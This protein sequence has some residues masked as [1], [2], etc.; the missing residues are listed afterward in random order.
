MAT[1]IDDMVPV[2]DNTGNL[3]VRQSTLVDNV[4]LMT[5]AN[6]TMT[7][8]PIMSTTMVNPESVSLLRDSNSYTVNNLNQAYPEPN[9]LFLK[10]NPDFG[11]QP[12]P[13]GYKYWIGNIRVEKEKDSSGKLVE[14]ESKLGYKP[15]W[16]T[17]YPNAQ[18]SCQLWADLYRC[19]ADGTYEKIGN[20]L[21]A[22]SKQLSYWEECIIGYETDPNNPTNQIPIYGKRIVIQ[23]FF[24]EEDF[25]GV[26]SFRMTAQGVNYP[27][28]G[29]GDLSW[30]SCGSTP[31]NFSDYMIK[32]FVNG[33]RFSDVRITE[34]AVVED[35]NGNRVKTN[36][37]ATWVGTPSTR[38]I[39]TLQN[40]CLFRGDCEPEGNRPPDRPEQVCVKLTQ[41][42]VAKTLDDAIKNG[43]SLPDYGINF[44]LTNIWIY[45]N[46]NNTYTKADSIESYFGSGR[47]LDTNGNPVSVKTGELDKTSTTWEA[48]PNNSCSEEEWLRGTIETYYDDLYR[49]L[50]ICFLKNT[51]G[52]ITI[53][54]T[55]VTPLD[56]T[57]Q[58]VYARESRTETIT[59]NERTGNTRP[60]SDP[61]CCDSAEF[62]TG[63]LEDLLII[64][65]RSKNYPLIDKFK[66]V[67]NRRTLPAIPLGSTLQYKLDTA[68]WERID[69]CSC[70][71]VLIAD[72][73]CVYQTEYRSLKYKAHINDKR[74]WVYAVN[75]R[76]IM[77]PECMGDP[78]VGVY[79][80]FDPK[81]DIVVGKRKQI[82]KGL[83]NKNESM[84]CYLTSST[85]II[86]NKKYY[87]D[88]SDCEN[89]VRSPYYALAYGNINGL[90][91]TDVEDETL[92]KTYSDTIYSQYQLICNDYGHFNGTGKTF[93]KFSFVSESVSIESDDIYAINFYRNGL[94][95]RLDPGNFQ[96]NLAY[97]SGSFYANSV[98]TGS[99]VKIGSS[100]IMTFI[101]DSNIYDEAILCDGGN[102]I[103]Y[104]IVSGSLDEGIYE[105]AS[106][107]TYGKVYPQLGIV[108]FHPKRLNELLGFNTVTGSNI[109]GDN[110]FKLFTSISGAAS[111]FGSRTDSYY[112]K[113]RNITYKT[114]THYFVRLYPQRFNYTNNQTFTSGSKNEVLYKCFIDDPQTYITS[115]G[116][117]DNNRQLMAIAKLSRPVKKNFDTDLLIKIRLNW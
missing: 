52:R 26:L 83:F 59:I 94:S 69:S 101:D 13:N 71:E 75:K 65:L 102:L 68:R 77:T 47:V 110:A 93:P 18:V 67:S 40:D 114:T 64:E 15:E 5:S 6:G 41:K 112:M 92:N 108:I 49:L 109:D 10:G 95:D 46:Q 58:R 82:T 87:Y 76:K 55:D 116:L 14:N 78:D 60:S 42:I 91:S 63:Y 53:Q 44:N 48:E 4:P 54:I 36:R 11:C 25:T 79:F 86:Q 113:A 74:T 81:K 111:P 12:G 89:C 32:T 29:D 117:Y 19:C 1:P 107:N 20:V 2:Y 70:E 98:H 21:V 88:I 28:T 66:N 84:L 24:F 50:E 9:S 43:T 90:G 37:D 61:K 115:I 104:N 96:I 16:K 22:T 106:I 27:P 99:N 30:G 8:D 3:I 23:Q 62:D 56:N 85:Q 80:P 34:A 38:N 57:G 51:D 103:A 33:Y 72:V 7:Y 35:A 97:L 45:N 100:S 39:L 17:T 73:W 31:T 105:N